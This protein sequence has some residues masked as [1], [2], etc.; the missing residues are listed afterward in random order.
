M[1]NL[2]L[3]VNQHIVFADKS[4]I[5]LLVASRRWGKSRLLLTE[6]IYRSLSFD[7]VIDPASPPVVLLCCPSFKQARQ[8][9]WQPL[10]SLLEGQPYVKNIDKSNFRIDIY[11]RPSILLRG[12][13]DSEG[14][15]LRGLKIYFAGL[16]EIQDFKQHSWTDAIYP[17]L[18]DT[19][20]SKCL[21]IGTPKGRTHWLYTMLR[22][23][24]LTLPD[25]SYHHF[26]ALDNPLL[27]KSF[28]ERARRDLPPRTFQQE[29]MADFLV[30]EG[31]LF[32]CFNDTHIIS[33]GN[34]YDRTFVAID[35]GSQNPAITVIG[36]KH[37]KYFLLDVWE[38]PHPGISVTIDE[39]I[40][41]VCR[42]AQQY[43]A[44]KV[45]C[46][47]DR[48]DIVLSLRRY[49]NKHNLP[50][51]KLTTL[52][53]RSKP[54]VMARIDIVNS[55]FKQDRFFINAKLTKTISEFQSFCRAQDKLG[56]YLD[57]PAEGQTDHSI[58]ATMYALGR[59]E[60]HDNILAR[61]EEAA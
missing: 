20:N 29:L 33:T 11:N 30:F 50:A 35:P 44:Y 46:P 3:H 45:F 19:P 9:H 54:G 38:N 41:Q 31:Q 49:G 60:L 52:I 12:A 43:N 10:L 53:K 42:F 2:N 5:R 13:N 32:D 59:L 40:A 55:L 14:D 58:F 4:F 7:Q 22:Q 23:N 28:I 56:N 34:P 47:D 26:S 25:W 48:G 24:A 18:L 1:T 27:P 51:L 61:E 16:D 36:L 39:L 15:G 21:A 37:Q 57:Q 8:I 17:A 6:V